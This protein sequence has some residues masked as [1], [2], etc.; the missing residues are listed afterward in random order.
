[1]K[2]LNNNGFSLIELII[3]MAIMAILTVAVAPQYL[4]YV[5]RSRKSVDVQTMASVVTAIEIY[6]ADPMAEVALVTDSATIKAGDTVTVNSSNDYIEK[7]LANAG[8]TSITLKSSDWASASNGEMTLNVAISNGAPKVTV[9]GQKTGL[10]IV[11]GDVEASTGESTPTAT[12]E[13]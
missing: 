1:M 5:E 7:A 3:V 12:P 6:A 9:T 13:P 2:K 8:I 4:K 10:D 11:T